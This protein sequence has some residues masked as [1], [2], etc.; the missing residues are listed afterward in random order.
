LPR[1][2]RRA[3]I[4]FLAERAQK[5]EPSRSKITS[6][7]RPVENH[8]SSRTPPGWRTSRELPTRT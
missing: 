6:I 2:N 4:H 7:W 1:E 3:A 8:C 5:H